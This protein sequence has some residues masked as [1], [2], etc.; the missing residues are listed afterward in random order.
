MKAMLAEIYRQKIEAVFSIEYEYH[1][2]NSLPEIA[3]CVKYFDK[4]VAILSGTR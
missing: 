3:E 1:W 4:A 2:D